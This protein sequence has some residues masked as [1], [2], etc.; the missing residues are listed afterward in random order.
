[1]REIA[2]YYLTGLNKFLGSDRHP[3]ERA[4]KWGSTETGLAEAKKSNVNRHHRR[5]RHPHSHWAFTR[6]E[7][8]TAQPFLNVFVVVV[9]HK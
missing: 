7:I 1:M 9:F 5:P 4:V 2:G 6:D 3:A 8:T